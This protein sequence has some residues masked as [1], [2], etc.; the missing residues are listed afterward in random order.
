MLMPSASGETTVCYDHSH[1]TDSALQ[2][3]LVYQFLIIDRGSMPKY[4]HTKK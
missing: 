1:F 2:I 3:S 4:I